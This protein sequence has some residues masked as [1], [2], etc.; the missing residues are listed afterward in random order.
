ML[1][2]MAHKIKFESDSLFFKDETDAADSA[3]TQHYV[4][5]SLL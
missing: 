2:S 1:F 4:F 3:A 5:F